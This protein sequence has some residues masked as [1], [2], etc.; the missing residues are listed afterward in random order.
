MFNKNK[1]GRYLRGVGV[2]NERREERKTDV[3]EQ[4]RY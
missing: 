2:G 3:E 4:V 1:V